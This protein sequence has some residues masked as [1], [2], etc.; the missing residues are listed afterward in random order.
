M[1]ST[2]TPREKEALDWLFGLIESEEQMTVRY[3]GDKLDIAWREGLTVEYEV[4]WRQ[5]SQRLMPDVV[6]VMGYEKSEGKRSVNAYPF[7][8]YAL[9]PVSRTCLAIEPNVSYEVTGTSAYARGWVKETINNLEI[10]IRG[11]DR[12]PRGEA[13]R[14]LSALKRILR[15]T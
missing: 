7:A 12:E 1:S 14:L 8:L 13:M 6:L 4:D 2:V 5:V 11:L 15:S 3:K 9:L 10:A